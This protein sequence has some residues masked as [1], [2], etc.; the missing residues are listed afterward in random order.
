MAHN[1]EEKE[2]FYPNGTLMYRGG[3]KKNDFGHDIYDGKGTIF[4]QEG[5]LLF[6]GEFANHMKQGNICQAYGHVSILYLPQETYRVK[7]SNVMWNNKKQ[8]G[9]NYAS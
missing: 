8:G 1:Y 2:I 4:D 3:V 5:E 9:K 7:P 6:E